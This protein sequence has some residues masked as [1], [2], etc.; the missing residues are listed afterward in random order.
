MLPVP[1]DWD[2]SNLTRLTF[3]QRYYA[4][5]D[6]LPDGSKIIFESDRAGAVKDGFLHLYV[7]DADGSN[8]TQLTRPMKK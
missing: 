6:W 5:P 7:M 4:Y 1:G 2:G 3:T 8:V